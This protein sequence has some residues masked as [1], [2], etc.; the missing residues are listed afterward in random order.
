LLDEDSGLGNEQKRWIL[1]LYNPSTEYNMKNELMKLQRETY[2]SEIMLYMATKSYAFAKMSDELRE[3]VCWK[4]RNDALQH[5]EDLVKY[6]SSLD[7]GN[8]AMDDDTKKWVA[9]LGQL[10]L[11]GLTRSFE[12]L[13]YATE[14]EKNYVEKDVMINRRNVRNHNHRMNRRSSK[15]KKQSSSLG[16]MYG[17]AINHAEYH[18]AKVNGEEPP[19]WD[20]N[21]DQYRHVT[22]QV[23]MVSINL[24]LPT[25][26]LKENDK[27]ISGEE[28]LK[29][30]K[31]AFADAAGFQGTSFLK[32]EDLC[33]FL[34]L[35]TILFNIQIIHA[36]TRRP[37]VV[38]AV[39]MYAKKL[40]QGKGEKEFWTNSKSMYYVGWVYH[41]QS[42]K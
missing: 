1:E 15:E 24:N 23:D 7:N 4:F 12:V 41:P 11:P 42:I 14:K 38:V 20:K 37:A 6:I 27:T 25:N 9:N 40:F 34:N 28:Q 18:T 35:S 13:H 19:I 5:Q 36:S 33:K 16:T 8:I 39:G 10:A 26:G 21:V 31:I 17:S 2:D 30:Q 29:R 32:K 3:E 22:H